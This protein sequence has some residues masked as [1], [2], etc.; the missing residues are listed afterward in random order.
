MESDAVT[1]IRTCG[2]FCGLIETQEQ[3]IRIRELAK[4]QDV[5][6]GLAPAESA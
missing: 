3:R 5:A 4:H 1:I 6:D 2:L